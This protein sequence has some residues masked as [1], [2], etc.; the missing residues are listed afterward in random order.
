MKNKM[1]KHMTTCVALT[2]PLDDA[3]VGS[4]NP[5]NPSSGHMYTLWMP[6]YRENKHPTTKASR[7]TRKQAFLYLARCTSGENE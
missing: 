6:Q 5:T 1:D 4:I 7:N 2:P 3:K